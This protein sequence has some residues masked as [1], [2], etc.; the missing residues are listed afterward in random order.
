MATSSKLSK[1][2]NGGIYRLIQANKHYKHH[3]W[4]LASQR[5]EDDNIRDET[6]TFT[7]IAP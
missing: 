1:N 6:S 2:D 7:S 3:L 4:E 5:Q